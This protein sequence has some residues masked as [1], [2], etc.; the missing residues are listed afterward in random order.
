MDMIKEA[1]ETID[2]SYPYPMDEV[3]LRIEYET[4]FDLPVGSFDHHIARTHGSQNHQ[5]HSRIN[6]PE[7]HEGEEFPA[8]RCSLTLIHNLSTKEMI[9]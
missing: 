1:L 5:S 6:P 7:C 9:M 4:L 8:N 3:N 2:S